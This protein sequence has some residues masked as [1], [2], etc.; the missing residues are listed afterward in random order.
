VGQG[1][2]SR[3]AWATLAKHLLTG[4]ALCL[5]IDGAAACRRPKLKPNVVLVTFD[6]TRADHISHLGYKRSTTPNLDFIAKEGV[7]YTRA[8]STSS[9]TAPSHASI[10][11]SLMPSQH[12]CHAMLGQDV[13]KINPIRPNVTMLAQLLGEAGFATAGFVGAPYVSSTFGFARGFDVYDDQWEGSHRVSREVNEKAFAW[14]NHE[15]TE[16]FFL[17]LHYYDPHA[18]YDPDPK[19]SYPFGSSAQGDEMRYRTFS[20][21]QYKMEKK[22]LPTDE[23]FVATI[24]DLYDQEIYAEDHSLGKLVVK[25][26]EI[27]AWDRTLLIVTSDHGEDFGDRIHRNVQLFDKQISRDEVLWEHG[28]TPYHSQCHVPLVIRL[29]AG[30]LRGAVVDSVVSNADIFT[31]VT[32]YLQ[33]PPPSGVAGE[34]L[35]SHAAHGPSPRDTMA[36]AERYLPDWYAATLWKGNV[37]LL[38]LTSTFVGTGVAIENLPSSPPVLPAPPPG[39]APPNARPSET[40][41]L[42]Q[43]RAALDVYRLRRGGISIDLPQRSPPDDWAVQQE[44]LRKKLKALG[45]GK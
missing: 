11:T 36:M 8:Y 42:S 41:T 18:P 10:F 40:E 22:D 24:I 45:Y 17:F 43:M 3:A 26:R 13:D 37:E 7:T 35:L 21:G 31:T 15:A 29:P 34:D 6:T 9:W 28:N 2:P 4:A 20:P 5:C 33:I 27:G 44:E 39:A 16:P 19:L 14:L 30:K 32:S 38:E 25:L 23:N 12:G 1:Y